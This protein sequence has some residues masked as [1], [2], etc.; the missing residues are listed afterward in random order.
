METI[1]KNIPK[2]EELQQ[3][4]LTVLTMLITCQLVRECMDDLRHTNYWRG[5]I[6]VHSNSLVHLIHKDFNQVINNIFEADDETVLELSKGL[7]D[8]INALPQL[9][10]DDIIDLAK[11]AKAGINRCRDCVNFCD[12]PACTA[13]SCKNK[14]QENAS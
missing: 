6:K 3:E 2:D 4:G 10:T 8:L 13:K 9:R 12:W 1:K 7:E 5:Q 11:T 14:T